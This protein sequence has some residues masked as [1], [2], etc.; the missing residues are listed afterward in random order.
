M[1][2][3]PQRAGSDGRIKPDIFPPS[4]FIAAA[5]DLAM[6]TPA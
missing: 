6:V 4:S 1:R 3:Q 2:F 5:V